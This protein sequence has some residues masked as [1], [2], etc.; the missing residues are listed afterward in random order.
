MLLE[1]T[2]DVE[3]I[4]I[5]TSHDF[6]TATYFDTYSLAEVEFR[7]SGNNADVAFPGVNMVA[8]M[9]SGGNSFHGSIPC[10]FGVS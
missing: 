3:G 2:L 6:N 9:K 4:N 5:T 10:H 7:T 1:P 8:V